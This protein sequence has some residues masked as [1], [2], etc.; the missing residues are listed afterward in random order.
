MK[1]VGGWVR[2]PWVNMELNWLLR[3]FAFHLSVAFDTI[4]QTIV[5][6]R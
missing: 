5:V 6:D 2:L 3:V 1:L 4:N